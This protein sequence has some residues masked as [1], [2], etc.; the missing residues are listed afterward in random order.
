LCGLQRLRCGA[1]DRAKPLQVHAAWLLSKRRSCS[2][3]TKE[4]EKGKKRK[5][6]KTKKKKKEANTVNN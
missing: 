4:K 2:K 6:E 3:L 1:E 5:K